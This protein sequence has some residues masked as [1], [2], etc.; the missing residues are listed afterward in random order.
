MTTDQLGLYQGAL[1]LLGDRGLGASGL[2]EDRDARYALDDVWAGPP[3]I[4]DR[5]LEMGLW[6]F[7]KRTQSLTQAVTPSVGFTYG[8]TRPA[9]FIRPYAFW[10]DSSRNVPLREYDAEGAVWS[11]NQPGIIVE[12]ISNGGSYGGNLALW[13]TSFA[14]YVEATMARLGAPRIKSSSLLEMQK[15]ESRRLAD[16]RSHSAMEGP[17]KQK[18]MGNWVRARMTPGRHSENR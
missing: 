6:R 13:P 16:A 8:F 4:I 12:Y 5:C 7:A 15:E 11:A 9:D 17:A 3:T 2:A 1:T 18:P 10:T 14:A